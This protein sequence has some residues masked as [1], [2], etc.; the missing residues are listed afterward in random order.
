MTFIVEKYF[1]TLLKSPFETKMK[2]RYV[3]IYIYIV[4]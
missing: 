1:D 2:Q 3:Y 4:I